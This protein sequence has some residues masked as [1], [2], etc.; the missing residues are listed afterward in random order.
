MTTATI[1]AEDIVRRYAEELAFVTEEDKADDLAALIDHLQTAAPRFATADINGHEDLET[2][3]TLL[4][5]AN[6]AADDT[7]R[8]VFLR[9]ADELLYPIVW[10]M[11]EGYR[12]MA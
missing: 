3:A 11:T 4:A 9:K 12:L 5:E 6:R 7:E 2:A 1:T 8:T 10:D